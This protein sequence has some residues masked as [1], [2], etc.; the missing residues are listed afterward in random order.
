MSIEQ[1]SLMLFLRKH[2]GAN[3]AATALF[4]YLGAHKEPVA[5]LD[6]QKNLEIPQGSMAK[7][8]RQLSDQVL[9]GARKG[10]GLAARVKNPTKKSRVFI[11]LTPKGREVYNEYM[12]FVEQIYPREDYKK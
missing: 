1:T 8:L 3:P 9:Q 4:L 7:T 10:K 12:D 6:I 11:A 5:S 2:V